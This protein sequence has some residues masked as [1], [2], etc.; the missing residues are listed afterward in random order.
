VQKNLDGF[1][2]QKGIV[3]GERVDH[4]AGNRQVERARELRSF[5][6]LTQEEHFTM[7]ELVP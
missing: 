3:V 1:V 5:L 4:M 6:Q 7:F 2:K